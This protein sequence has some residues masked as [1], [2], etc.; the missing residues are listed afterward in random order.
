[1][2]SGDLSLRIDEVEAVRN[3]SMVFSGLTVLLIIVNIRALAV[4]S[5][6]LMRMSLAFD[7][8]SYS[9]CKVLPATSFVRFWAMKAMDSSIDGGRVRSHESTSDRR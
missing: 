6:L 4:A 8:A 7:A 3:G 1:M 9:L 2:D 5:S